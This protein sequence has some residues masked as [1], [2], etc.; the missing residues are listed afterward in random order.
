MIPKFRRSAFSC[1]VWNNFS[2]SLGVRLCSKHAI[3]VAVEGLRA[4][5]GRRATGP[6]HSAHV[7]AAATGSGDANLITRRPSRFDAVQH[8]K[9][10]ECELAD[11]TSRHFRVQPLRPQQRRESELGSSAT[12]AVR[13]P[14]MWLQSAETTIKLKSWSTKDKILM[15]LTLLVTHYNYNCQC[16]ISFLHF[17]HVSTFLLPI[18]SMK[19]IC[20][21]PWNQ[22]IYMFDVEFSKSMFVVIF[23]HIVLMFS[24]YLF[25]YTDRNINSKLK[26]SSS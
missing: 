15:C 19:F 4:R 17:T 22:E 21:L 18:S 14:C 24:S 8:R 26:L 13:P 16:S 11:L 1:V 10:S 20:F 2:K 5:A 3:D 6:S 23:T 7:G 25:T 9:V 12:S